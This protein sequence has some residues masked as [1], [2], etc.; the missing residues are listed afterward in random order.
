MSQSV[1]AE[2]VILFVAFFRHGRFEIG[3][4]GY[5]AGA[6]IIYDIEEQCVVIFYVGDYRIIF[7]EIQHDKAR[8][9]NGVFGADE[10]QRGALAVGGYRD[11]KYLL[12]C[13]LPCE[14]LF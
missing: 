14:Y 1:A 4:I 3:R 9:C 7:F 13:A 10:Y 11:I 2:R 8:I 5:Y 12:L 6:R